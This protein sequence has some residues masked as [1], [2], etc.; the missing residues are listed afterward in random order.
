VR[1]A[2]S[3]EN[4]L[5]MMK[6]PTNSAIVAKT[7]RKVLK[8]PSPCLTSLDCSLASAC[9]VMAWVLAGSTAATRLRRSV[10]LTP[11]SAATVISVNLP[12]RLSTRWAVG[13]SK[14]ISVSP[15][16][17][18]F[19]SNVTMPTMVYVFSGASVRTGAL[20]PTL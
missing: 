6:A 16:N 19:P 14:K 3:I 20:S 5:K 8:K 4:V 11:L 2:T 15:A 1:C 10:S 17:D 9:P 12:S 7:S 13:V 18:F